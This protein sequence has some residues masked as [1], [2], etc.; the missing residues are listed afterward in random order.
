MELLVLDAKQKQASSRADYAEVLRRLREEKV[1]ATTILTLDNVDGCL[2]TWCNLLMPQMEQ[3]LE[4][5]TAKPDG[6][7]PGYFQY[8]LGRIKAMQQKYG[9]ALNLFQKAYE[10]DKQF[11]HPL[12]EQINIFLALGQLD[13]AEYVLA[14]LK[15]ASANSFYPRDREIAR[16]EADIKRLRNQAK[17]P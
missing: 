15:Q 8:R 3:W 10:A 13:N 14:I 4:I 2:Q 5:I 7:E 6:P 16:V 12:F 1:T 9:E 11:L 17:Q